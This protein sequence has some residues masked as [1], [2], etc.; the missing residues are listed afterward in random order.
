MPR[1]NLRKAQRLVREFCAAHSVS[2]A[3]TSLLGSY[4]I[5]LRHL[6]ALGAPLR[7]RR[8]PAG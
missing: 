4:V 8:G 3:E 7:P 2:Y 1:P 6:H 5:V